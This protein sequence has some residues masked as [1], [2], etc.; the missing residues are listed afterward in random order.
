MQLVSYGAQDIYISGNPQITFWKVLYKRH[1]NFAMESIEVTF[2]GQAD[3]G[4]RVT[5]VISRNADLMYRTYIQVTLPQI[6]LIGPNDRF[7]W[8]N[9]VGHRLINT[10]EIEIGGSRIDKQ[11]GDWM[12]IWTQLTQ[13]LG[14]QVSFDD[15]VGNSADLVLLKDGS[16]VALDATCAA[17][18]A[19]NSCLSRAGTPMKTLFIP[20]QFWY[21][22][23]PGLAI[24]LIALQYHEVRINVEF[25][26]N[27]NCCYA[28]T[29]P[30]NPANLPSNGGVVN[31]GNGVTAVSQ[32]QLVA[33]S[34]YIDYIYLDTEERRRFAQQSHEYLIDQLQFTGDETVTAS[35]NKIQMN[36]NHPTKE[37]IWVVQRDSFVDCNSP[38]TPWVSEALGQQPFNYSDDWSTEGIVTAVLGRGALATNGANSTVPVPTWSLSSGPGAPSGPSGSAYPQVYLPGLGAASGAGLSTGSEIY[39]SAGNA[40]DDSFFEGTTNYLLAKVILASNVKC[41]GKNPVEVAKIQL[42]GQDRFDEREGRYFDK[43]QPWQHHTRTPSTGINVYSFALK[44]E[45][46]QPSGTCNFSRID[47]ATLNLTLS[48]NT[49]RSQRTAKVRIYAV[50]YNVLRVMSGMGGLAYS[51]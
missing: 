30:A 28:D 40:Q 8:L 16:G 31:L 36:F 21:C 25:Q 6:S 20:L 2:N 26:Q 37:L 5:A 4:R 22:R 19:T 50:N 46:H 39:D 42:N 48:V 1:T 33:A 45:E 17:S 35:S 43:V 49:V 13:P 29:A 27:Y 14:T 12:Q 10:V 15:M 11:Y 18:E 32:L 23:N 38:P 34:I 9:Y 44:P 47:K 3:F 7:R 41:E 51:N 24:P